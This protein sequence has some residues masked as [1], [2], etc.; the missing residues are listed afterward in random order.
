[1]QK[2]TS[3]PIIGEVSHSDEENV[4]VVNRT[5]RRFI[6]EQFRIIRTNL[7]YV[8][9]KQDKFVL[10]ITSSA[11]GEGKSFISTNVGAVMAITGKK[12][13]IL[14]FDIRKPKIMSTLGLQ[15][16]SGVT[17]YIIGKA[18]YE[19]LIVKVPQ[20]DNLYVIPCGP[21]P[22]N[23]SEL[24]LTSRLTELMDRLKQD[25]DVL[26]IDTAPIGLVSDSVILGKFADATL[27]VV[28]HNQTFKKQL[29]LLREN[30]SKNRLPRISIVIN[31]IKANSSYG[32]YYGY[33]GN[34]YE[35]YGY[36]YGTQYFEDEISHRGFFGRLKKI[37]KTE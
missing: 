30:H 28:R 11:S 26:V 14:E 24:F 1:V 2:V 34:G 19:E 16:K 9:P 32:R 31:D 12:T 27:Y 21:V 5:S 20:V 7:Q 18:S 23:P 35:G 10:M 3:A 6:A 37:F 25:F 36:G 22:P 4:L 17:N 13:A 29:Q 33:G 8:L 15:R